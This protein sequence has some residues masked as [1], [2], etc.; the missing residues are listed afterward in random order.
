MKIKPY[1]TD[2]YQFK[3]RQKNSEKKQQPANENQLK[4]NP[5]KMFTSNKV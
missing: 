4:N 1:I 5:W 2:Y 3:E